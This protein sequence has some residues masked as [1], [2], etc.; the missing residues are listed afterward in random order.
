MHRAAWNV[1][2]IPRLGVDRL[3]ARPECGGALQDIEGLVL[4]VVQ[5]RWRASSR[6]N[7]AL[8]D[9]TVSVRFRARGEKRDS[10]A[11]PAIHR[12]GSGRDILGLILIWHGGDSVRCW[13]W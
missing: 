5:V 4:G 6:R 10:V 12:A 2:E 13:W 7:D 1:D 9:E 8:D 11:R 3:P